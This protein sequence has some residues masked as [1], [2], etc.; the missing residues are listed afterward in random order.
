MCAQNAGPAAFHNIA[1]G[2]Q[3]FSTAI[4]RDIFLK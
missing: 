2:T 1:F 4:S 3:H